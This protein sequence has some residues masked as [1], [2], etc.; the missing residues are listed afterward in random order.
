MK[1]SAIVVISSLGAILVLGVAFLLF[2][3]AAI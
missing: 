3:A 1:K 2:I